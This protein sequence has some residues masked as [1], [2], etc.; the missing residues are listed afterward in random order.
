MEITGDGDGYYRR[1][2]TVIGTTTASSFLGDGSFLTG[3]SKSQV[4]LS[5]VDNVSDL[6]KPISTL[7]QQ[8][9]DSNYSYTTS[10][11]SDLEDLGNT[12]GNSVI[13]DVGTAPNNLPILDSQGLLSRSIFPSIVLTETF[14]VA[15]ESEMLA[16]Q[17][18]SGDVAVRTDENKTYILKAE[19]PTNISNWARAFDA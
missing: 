8:S 18:Q 10:V 14:V 7:V 16:I 9:L 1:N 4:G 2:L 15:S 13:Y 5:E 11:K 19:P 6:N 17:G 3:L 12:L